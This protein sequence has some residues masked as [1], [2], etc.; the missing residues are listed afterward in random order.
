MTRRRTAFLSLLL[1]AVCLWLALFQ[2]NPLVSRAES[3]QRD[4]AVA[5]AATYA[6]LRAINGALSMA[7]EVEVGASFMV[8]GSLQ[9]LR[10]LE[11][12]DDTVERASVLV[13]GVA[14]ITGI[15]SMSMGP[16]SAVGFLLLA[17]GLIGRCGGETA[18]G[19]ERA[20]QPLRRLSGGCGAIGLAFA[21]GLPL[22]FV[23]GAAAGEWLTRADWQAA[24]ATLDGIAGEARRLVADTALQE[25][26][27]SWREAV[28][29]YFGAA[30]MFWSEADALF[31]ASL[32]LVGIYLLRM[33]ILP[34]LMLVALWALAR[35]IWPA[36]GLR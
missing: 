10:W 15:L 34:T 25:D 17:A 33:L 4:V 24:N 3:F 22:A 35:R 32:T 9:P 1:A 12:V 8:S 2:H 18:C 13:L 14:L 31:G 20:P 5:T 36:G 11:P 16:I 27:R 19:W 30:S 28:A 21:I 29:A 26:E 6:S 23:L 7:E